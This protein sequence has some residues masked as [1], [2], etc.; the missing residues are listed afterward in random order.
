MERLRDGWRDGLDG[1]SRSLTGWMDGLRD[2]WRDDEWMDLLITINKLF[3]QHLYR[4]D[5]VP[6]LLIHISG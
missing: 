2:G 6:S 4:N 3:K 1:G 5:S